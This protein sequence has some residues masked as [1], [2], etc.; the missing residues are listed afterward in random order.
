LMTRLSSAQAGGLQAGGV[1]GTRAFW[2]AFRLG[3]Q[4]EEGSG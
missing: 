1:A 3:S 4:G 2:Q